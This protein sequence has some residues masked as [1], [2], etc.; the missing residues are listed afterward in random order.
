MTEALPI[1][2]NIDFGY[3][4]GY[5][6]SF[7]IHGRVGLKFHQNAEMSDKTQLVSSF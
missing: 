6:E 5:S 3:M 7:A 2:G 4:F 1:A